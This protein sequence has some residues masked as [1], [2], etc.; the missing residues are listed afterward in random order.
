MIQSYE[1]LNVVGEQ[2]INKVTVISYAQRVN[3][4]PAFWKNTRPTYGKSVKRYLQMNHC[5]ACVQLKGLY[6]SNI[7]REL[8]YFVHPHAI[9]CRN[10]LLCRHCSYRQ[11]IQGVCA[12]SCPKCSLLFLHMTLVIM[13]NNVLI[14]YDVPS[15]FHAP[16]TWYA[17]V[18]TPHSKP[19]KGNLQV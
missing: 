18:P 1:W 7:P 10:H 6:A 2:F 4:T 11:S 3:I 14:I 15:I 17:A 19:W 5:M 16:S 9:C 8:W 13:F 12:W